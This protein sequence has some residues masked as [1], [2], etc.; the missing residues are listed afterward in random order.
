MIPVEAQI[1]THRRKNYDM[2]VNEELLNALLDLVDEQRDKAQL[3]V[4]KY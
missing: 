4:T 2:K 1:P 3:R